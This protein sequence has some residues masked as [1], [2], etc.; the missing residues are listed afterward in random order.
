MGQLRE[1]ARH[2]KDFDSLHT[3]VVAISTDDQEHAL[4]VWQ[5]YL[6][7]D[8]TVLSDPGAQVIRSFGLIHANAGKSG[9]DIALDTILLVDSDGTERW[10]Q[11]SD[12]LTGMPTAEEAL[13]RIRES[14]TQ[15]SPSKK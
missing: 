9:E 10:R 14:P 6:T 8:F 2:S 12:T 3:R 15:A 11:V 13:K 1:F 5:K 7:K 4:L